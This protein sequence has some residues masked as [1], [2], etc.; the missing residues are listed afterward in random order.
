MENPGEPREA[1]RMTYVFDPSYLRG[2]LFGVLPCGRP[3]LY[4]GLRWQEV[5][6]KDKKTGEITSR[7]SLTVRR[8]RARLPLSFLDLVNNGVQGTAAS[9]LRGALERIEDEPL[10]E[11]VL[12]THDEVICIVREADLDAARK[13][14]LEIMLDLPDWAEGLPV[15][16][17]ASD[18]PWYSKC[19]D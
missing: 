5:E 3:L 11:T 2:T 1:G 14:L 16:A 15:Q 12:T 6:R 18:N 17:E 8:A 19:A 4:P 13:R 10:L 9:L 7:M